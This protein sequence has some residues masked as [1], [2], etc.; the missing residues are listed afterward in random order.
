M[1]IWTRFLLAVFPL[2]CLMQGA[3]AQRLDRPPILPAG[4]VVTWDTENGRVLNTV[5]S[6]TA[7]R[8][9][10][11][12]GSLVLVT[13]TEAGNPVR[14]ERDGKEVFSYKPYYP[15]VQ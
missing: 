12:D 5:L 8:S 11:P 7:W 10:R 14:G 13:H 4:T 1:L 9:V 3:V 2:L 6:A 15:F